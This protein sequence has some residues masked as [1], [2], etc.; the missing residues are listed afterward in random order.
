MA[1]RRHLFVALAL[2]LTNIGISAAFF[3]KPL[4]C[5]LEAPFIPGG[6]LPMSKDNDETR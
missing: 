2:V 4:Q 1:I 6:I 5:S 3:R